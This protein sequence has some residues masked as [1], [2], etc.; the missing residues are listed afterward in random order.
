MEVLK[1]INWKTSSSHKALLKLELPEPSDTKPPV[2][3]VWPYTLTAEE[4]EEFLLAVFSARQLMAGFTTE[5]PLPE[6]PQ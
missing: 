5:P 3:K 1:S 6:V 2:L 4:V